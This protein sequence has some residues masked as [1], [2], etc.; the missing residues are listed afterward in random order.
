ME[1]VLAIKPDMI[2]LW[3]E[4]WFGFAYCTSTY[5]QRTAMY[6][7]QRLWYRY[8]S[9]AYKKEYMAYQKKMSALDPDDDRTYLEN[10]LLPDPKQVKIRVYA[11]QST[12]KSFPL[13][14]RGP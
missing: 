7:A 11:N 10:R 1:E 8:R 13:C 4:A 14:A 6:N 5:R 3:D 2:F 9:E 12:H